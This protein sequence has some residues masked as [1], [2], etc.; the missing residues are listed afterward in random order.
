MIFEIEV[1]VFP[2]GVML[3]SSDL[4]DTVTGDRV[5]INGTARLMLSLVDGRRTAKEIGETVAAAYGI[6]PHRVTSDFLQLAARLNEKCLLNFDTPLRSRCS[7]FPKVLKL[8]L[9]EVVLGQLRPPWRRKRLDF[10]NGSRRVGFLSVARHLSL[11]AA[12]IGAA[13][14]LALWLL[15]SDVL[16]SFWLAVSIALA[17]AV[18]L[19]FHE[20]AHAMALAPVSAFLSVYG[21]VF[22]V[23]H[24]GIPPS[25]GFLVS[26]AGPTIPGVLGLLV[27]LFS[28]LLRSECLVFA[29]EVLSM[30][31]LGMTAIAADG[32]KAVRNLVLVLNPSEQRGAKC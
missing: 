26:A 13:L 1:P 12:M 31:L 7:T 32:R 5:P 23:G 27:I 22:L 21:P 17:F 29:G 4:L 19:V 3:E 9:I 24:P 30:N 15:M 8:F 16:P 20:A 25:K 6:A 10:C 11:S 14:S 18:S 28:S 2:A